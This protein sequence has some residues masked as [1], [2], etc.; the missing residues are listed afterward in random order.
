MSERPVGCEET[1]SVGGTSEGGS[2]NNLDWRRR[3][4]AGDSL[5]AA[6][7]TDAEDA[8]AASTSN[9]PKMEFQS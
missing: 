4:A 9:R 8:L 2:A 5:A 3:V 7:C 1:A 6:I